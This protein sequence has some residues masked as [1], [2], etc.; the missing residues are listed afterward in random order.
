MLPIKLLDAE[1]CIIHIGIDFCLRVIN[2]IILWLFIPHTLEEA[3]SLSAQNHHLKRSTLL[4]TLKAA[5]WLVL[6]VLFDL[7]NRCLLGGFS[8][9]FTLSVD[10]KVV[11]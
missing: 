7:S 9:H 10:I 11:E 1:I 6:C 2:L 4:A 3:D 5:N 8:F